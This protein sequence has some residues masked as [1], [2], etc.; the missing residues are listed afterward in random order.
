MPA[1][2]V[3]PMKNKHHASN[4]SQPQLCWAVDLPVSDYREIHRLQL[5]MVAARYSGDLDRDAIFIL[6]H[7]PVFTLGRNGKRHH[8]IVDTNLS[9]EKEIPVIRIERGG[10]ITYHG[11][12]QVVGYPIINLKSA[13]LSVKGYVTALEE[14]MIRTAKDFGITARR[15]TINPGVWVAERKLGSVGVAVRHGITFHGFALNIN[16]DLAPFSRINPCGLEGVEM[17]S[18]EKEGAANVSTS[19]VRKQIW[20]HL[21]EQIHC[22]LD[23]IGLSDLPLGQSDLPVGLSAKQQSISRPDNL[24]TADKGRQTIRLTAQSPTS[25]PTNGRTGKPNWLRRR[26]PSGPEHEKVRNLIHEKGLHTVCQQAKCP[27]QFECFSQQTATFLILGDRCT[28]NCGFCNVPPGPDQPPNPK[29][30]QNVAE[31]ARKMKLTYVVIT[32]VTRDDLPDG[33]AAH[34]ADTIHDVREAIEGVQVE[35]LIPD[36]QGD[37]NALNTVLAAGPDV[38][39][40]NVETVRRLYP[41]V[42]PQ[43]D[44]RQ[45][46]TLLRRVSN[47]HSAIPAKSGIML[48]LG[49]TDAEIKRCLEDILDTGC[50][51]LTIGQY[52]QPTRNHLPVTRFVPPQE[53]DDWRS[54]AIKLGFGNVASG[55]F[56]R[57]SYHAKDLYRESGTSRNNSLDYHL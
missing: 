55:P 54:T 2:Q 26:L 6:E 57:S 1:L 53:F 11:P 35:V 33:G 47:H 5:D 8:L 19:A 7:E 9:S 34:F 25:P 38:L 46:L 3:L 52:L 13:G 37:E 21:A 48:G 22:Q 27:N 44:Y 51:I 41:L 39:N 50:H 18:F 31:A 23:Y 24:S 14:I 29:E 16:P 36:F 10:E 30:P 4:M 12:G 28:R 42:R 32:S 15:K 56:V 49:E 20:H 45:S 17:T 43:A 40:H